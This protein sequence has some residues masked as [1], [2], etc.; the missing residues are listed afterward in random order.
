VAGLDPYLNIYS[1]LE[2]ADMK[3]VCCWIVKRG[4]GHRSQ[5]LPLD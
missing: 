5:T 3:Q 1:A 4:F 2:F